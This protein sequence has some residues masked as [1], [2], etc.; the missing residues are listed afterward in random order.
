L[1]GEI[2]EPP[3]ERLSMAAG[4]DTANKLLTGKFQLTVVEGKFR[5]IQLC[6]IWSEEK[7]EIKKRKIDY[8]TIKF[9]VVEETHSR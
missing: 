3:A 9:S 7:I 2:L 1:T 5:E 6:S 4:V 8:N